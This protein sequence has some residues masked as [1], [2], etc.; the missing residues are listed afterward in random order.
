M[1]GQAHGGAAHSYGGM[2]SSSSSSAGVRWDGGQGVRP[3][4][5][6]RDEHE[7]G[8]GAPAHTD[9]NYN[10]GATWAASA[11]GAYDGGYGAVAGA[12]YGSSYGGGSHSEEGASGSLLALF[13]SSGDANGYAAA[14]GAS[15]SGGGSAGAAHSVSQNG[16]HN[17]RY[18]SSQGQG[19]G[20]HQEHSRQQYHQ[21]QLLQQLQ[22][23]LQQQRQAVHPQH[24]AP[25]AAREIVSLPR[26]RALAAGLHNLGNTCFMN[27]TL[28]CLAATPALTQMLADGAHTA[29]CRTPDGEVCMFCRLGILFRLMTPAPGGNLGPV[30]PK[31]M[32][33][34]LRLLNRRF[35]LGRQEDS[36]EFLRCLL[37][38]MHQSCLR[39]AGVKEGAPGRADETDDVHA[40]FGGYFRNQVHCTRCGYDSNTFDAFLDLSLEIDG[41]IKSVDAA[42]RHFSVSS[43]RLVAGR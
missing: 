13:H 21:Q 36:H 10:S 27:S 1:L 8:N 37:E 11:G 3:A 16:Y 34:H 28:Q 40:L 19:Q 14:T 42:L 2:D 12:G 7:A 26:H 39:S 17:P 32:A 30:A 25:A 38:R 41:G 18:S 24:V 6:Y 31:F 43:C 20:R 5:G 35:R 33:G 9:Y 4:R 23:R 22:P 15:S 29:T